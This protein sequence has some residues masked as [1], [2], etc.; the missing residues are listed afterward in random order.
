MTPQSQ[1]LV[2]AAVVFVAFYVIGSYESEVFGCDF[3]PMSWQRIFYDSW[4][5]DSSIHVLIDSRFNETDKSQLAQGLIN[6]SFWSDANCSHVTFYGFETMDMSGIAVS[7]LPPENTVW[8][9]SETTVDAGN[10]PPGPISDNF[11]ARRR[12]ISV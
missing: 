5:P 6:W 10:P 12:V 7:D 2:F 8:I 11:K 1:R 4:R 3:P 9:I